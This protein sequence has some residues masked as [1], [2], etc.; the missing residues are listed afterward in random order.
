MLTVKERS[1]L[2]A[3]AADETAAFQIGKNGVTDEFLNSVSDALD[4][5]EIVK[6]SVLK[7]ADLSAKQ[8]IAQVAD[9][10]AAE[11]VIAIGHKIVV[12]RKS[13]RDKVKHILDA[14][15]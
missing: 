7:N 13:A 9:A 3:V 11:P 14:L 10:L 4:A 15:K 12:Y 8:L 5:H 1:Y 2:K 6:I